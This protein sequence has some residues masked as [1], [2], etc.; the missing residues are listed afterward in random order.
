MKSM[1]KVLI[2]V[3]AVAL[4]AALSVYGTFAYLHMEQKITNTFTKGQVSI[5]FE[6]E[7]G[8]PDKDDPTIRNFDLVPGTSVTKNPKITVAANSLDSY[9]FIELEE[10][11][12]PSTL[13]F[14]DYIVYGATTTAQPISGVE[15]AT[16]KWAKVPGSSNKNVWYIKYTKTDADCVYT[17]LTDGANTPTDGKVTIVDFDQDAADA[18]ED[19]SLTVYSGAIQ[20]TGFTNALA[21]WKELAGN[22]ETLTK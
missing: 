2:A 15:G 9:L 14:S 19:I 18:L 7:G 13:N 21:A 3:T 6:E 11:I 8:T 17:F 20:D 1:K 4:V 22:D 16:A 12:K 10:T 5:T